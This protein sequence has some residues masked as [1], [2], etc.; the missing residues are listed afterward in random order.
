VR[1]PV[2]LW[3]AIGVDESPQ[4]TF[5]HLDDPEVTWQ[6]VK[7]QRNAD[8]SEAAVWEKWLAFSPDPQYLSLYA[9]YDPGMIVRRHGHFSPHVVFVIE[10]GAWFGER[11]CP[12]GTH[13]ELPQ[14]AAFGPIRAG[15]DGAVMFEVMLGDPRSWGDRPE[16]FRRVLDEQGAEPLPDVE[17][18]YPEW[19]Q[20]L[21]DHWVDVD[22]PTAHATPATVQTDRTDQS[23]Q[24]AETEQGATP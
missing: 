11:W 19:L 15:D 1:R 6:Q 22:T 21:R 3:K 9:R 2:A 23:D 13:V 8:G 20:D 17:L 4:P 10:G 16:E 14:G 12:A 18:D 24:H 7:R 5:R